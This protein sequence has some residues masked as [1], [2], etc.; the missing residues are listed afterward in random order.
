[1]YGFWQE[2]QTSDVRLKKTKFLFEH[3]RV[4]PLVSSMGSKTRLCTATVYYFPGKD[5]KM[6]C[7]KRVPSREDTDLWLEQ[8]VNLFTKSARIRNLREYESPLVI[9]DQWTSTDKK[10]SVTC[11]SWLS[12][13]TTITTTPTKTT[14]KTTLWKLCTCQLDDNETTSCGS[15]TSGEYKSYIMGHDTWGFSCLS[16]GWC[17]SVDSTWDPNTL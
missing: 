9:V 2:G 1:M 14:T 15:W 13:A 3:P 11:R 17:A 4:Q 8:L 7:I 16:I 10:V 12:S 5:R 6:Y